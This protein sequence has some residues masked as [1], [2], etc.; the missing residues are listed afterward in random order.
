M[1]NVGISL[2]NV[3]ESSLT[4]KS[5]SLMESIQEHTEKY[6]PVFFSSQSENIN[7]LVR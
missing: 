7:I 3:N 5:E 6:L 2:V 1:K 4:E